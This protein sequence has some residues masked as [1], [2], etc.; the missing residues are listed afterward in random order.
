MYCLVKVSMVNMKQKGCTFSC[1]ITVHVGEFVP[2][3]K[4]LPIPTLPINSQ[5]GAFEPPVNTVCELVLIRRW[6]LPAVDSVC[7][8]GYGS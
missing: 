8:T 7:S 4:T 5:L 2:L 1:V 3:K 6:Y